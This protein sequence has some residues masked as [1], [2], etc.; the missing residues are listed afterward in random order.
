MRE[1][2]VPRRRRRRNRRSRQHD[3]FDENDFDFPDD[4]DVEEWMIAQVENVETA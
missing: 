2:R 1:R 3:M 4:Y